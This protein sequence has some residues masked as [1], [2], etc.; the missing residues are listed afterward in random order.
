[1]VR[2]FTVVGTL[3][4]LAALATG[5]RTVVAVPQ[6]AQYVST[7]S[8]GLVWVTKTDNSVVALG[9][10]HVVGDTLTGFV[11]GGDYVEMP[12]STVQSMRA[13][14]AAKGHTYLLVGGIALAG[15]VATAVVVH[16]ASSGPDNSAY[17]QQSGSEC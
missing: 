14:V 13:S 2:Q 4:L 7:K 5:C 16:G 12:L 11:K 3:L 8:P 9:S 6:P 17:C 15:A 1:M 10:P